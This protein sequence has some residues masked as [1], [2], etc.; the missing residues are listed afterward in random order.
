MVKRLSDN[1]N[2][3]VIDPSLL[4]DLGWNA[5][6]LQAFVRKYEDAFKE[7][8]ANPA[9]GATEMEATLNSGEVVAGSR[10]AQSVGGVDT[11]GEAA[12]KDKASSLDGIGREGVS[13][14]YRKLVDEYYRSL[15]Q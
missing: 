2:A 14:E 6:Q 13:P 7:F 1:A 11:G 15:S 12:Q 10:G 3:K 8:D 4:T 9:E 5:S